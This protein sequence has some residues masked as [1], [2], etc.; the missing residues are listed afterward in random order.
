MIKYINWLIF[1]FVCTIL[2]SIINNYLPV[3]LAPDIALMLVAYMAFFFSYYSALIAIIIISYFASIFSV[4]SIWFYIFSYTVVFY[5]LVFLRKL[6]SRSQGIAIATIAII[7]TLL[8]PFSVLLLSAL[9]QHTSLFVT[10][11]Y[12]ALKQ[13]PVNILCAYILF[14]YLPL[15]CYKLNAKFL[16]AKI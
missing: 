15:V 5:I 6:F 1:I 7:T 11:L 9:S 10:A 2:Q 4:G 3:Y 16:S 13:I 14:K 12:S 8:Y